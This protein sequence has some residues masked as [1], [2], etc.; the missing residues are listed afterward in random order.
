VAKS[1][2]TPY[3]DSKLTHFLQ[4]SLGGE[5]KMLMIVCASPC[6]SDAQE[7]KCSL[8]FATRVGTVEL[9][10]AKRRGDGGAGAA[11]KEVRA[12]KSAH[13]D[14]TGMQA[15]APGVVRV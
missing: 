1:K 15:G 6:D 8:E 12:R 5:A 2:H 3:R 9:G 7:S 13:T 11:L 4:D 14:L 10:N